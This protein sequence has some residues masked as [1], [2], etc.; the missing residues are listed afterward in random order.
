MKAFFFS[1]TFGMVMVLSSF[2]FLPTVTAAVS[3]GN[4]YY[5]NLCGTGL[6][7]TADTCNR[8]CSTATGSCG[9]PGNTV[10]KFT[11]DGKVT[12]CRNNESAFASSQNVTGVSCG[13]TVQI[14][15]F[16]KACRQNGT[17]VCADANLRDYMVWYS[18]DC[19]LPSVTPNPTATP[20][21]APRPTISP[22]PT[23]V[24]RP[25]HTPL[26]TLTPAPLHTSSCDALR[27][28]SGNDSLVP[29]TVTLR[30]DARDSKGNIQNYRYYFGDGS[31]Q[32]TT[33]PETTKK[34][35]VSGSFSARVEVQDSS[36]N[37]KSSDSCMVTVTVKSSPI[38]SHKSACSYVNIYEGNN[39]M[40]PTTVRA[41]VAGFDNKNYIQQYKIDYGNG[42]TRESVNPIFEQ[43]F[44]Q[45]G[46]WRMKAYIKDSEGNWVGGDNEC[47]KPLYIQTKPLQ[48]QPNTGTPTIFTIAGLIAACISGA[49][50]I[51]QKVKHTAS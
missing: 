22:K 44:N 47:S 31:S 8:G 34:Y 39:A 37:W 6:N 20:T 28:V 15:I 2:F 24:P 3:Y 14:D 51:L 12:E 18:G 33:N 11:C 42:I 17:W 27:I 19:I 1:L 13:K 7:A 45:A 50:L 38:E 46:T 23:H 9:A 25:T 41:Q 40:A 5:T 35:E 26:P 4:G 32:T 36:G 10:V 16:D 29:A 21:N 49:Y 30:T 43:Q 48:S